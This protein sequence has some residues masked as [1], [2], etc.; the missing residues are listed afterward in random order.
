[1]IDIA[2]LV[3][4]DY[5]AIDFVRHQGRW[6]FNELEDTVGARM[7]YDLTPWTPWP[8]IAAISKIACKLQKTPPPARSFLCGWLFLL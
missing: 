4:A 3:Q 5:Y 6:I 2:A 1:M 8:I 7:L